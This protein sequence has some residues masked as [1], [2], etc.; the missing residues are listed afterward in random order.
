MKRSYV[1][2]AVGLVVAI[3]VVSPALGG[4]SL[5]DLVRDEV[6]KQLDVAQT[7]K[8]KKKAKPGPQGPAGKDGAQGP[9]GLGLTSGRVDDMVVGVHWATPIGQA[10]YE[11]N[12][13]DATIFS[14]TTI[15][16]RDLKV[17]LEQPSFAVSG[18]QSWHFEFYVDP[19][20]VGGAAAS[21]FGCDIVAPTSGGD[22]VSCTAPGPLTI[23]ADAD[24]VLEIV[25]VN[26]PPGL[27]AGVGAEFSW[28]VAPS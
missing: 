8:K 20:P 24:F 21:G 22:G 23:P 26:S 5:R 13:Q 6:A 27:G 4:P 12:Y 14:G 9:P 25:P 11:L 17:R 10:D 3:L 28:R 18:A 2:G 15:V 7:A 16:A 19:P 1:V